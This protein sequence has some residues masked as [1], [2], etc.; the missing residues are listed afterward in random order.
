MRLQ[1][2]T[3]DPQITKQLSALGKK[4]DEAYNNNDAAAVAALYTEDAVVV[5]DTGPIYGREAI[6]KHWADVFKQV[7]FSK[8]LDKADQDSPHIIGTAGNEAWSNGEWSTTIQGQNFG[9]V[10]SKGY[11]S[12]ITVRE[13]D[14]WRKRMQMSNVARNNQV[15]LAISFAVPAF[16]QQKDTVD[17][18]IIEQL[19]ALGKKFDEAW[20]NNDATALAVL[21]T[22]D[23]V[24]VTD[25][26]PLYG[27]EAIEKGYADLFKQVHFSN[28][29]S[30]RD[31]Y[32]PHIIG[33]AGNEVWS[34]GE[35]SQTYQV[36]G[37]DPIQL[38]GYWS[39]IQVREGDAWKTRMTMSNVTP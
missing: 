3:A 27:R 5:A 6:E 19:D 33:T 15:G 35:W 29:I 26:G 9:P 38:K 34:N 23:A 17:P 21:Y 11:F 7:H 28:R 20:K 30:K 37:G 10:H 18:Q 2:D 16:A 39:N 1:K 14:V 13:G 32:S 12:S 4:T 31:Q 24:R 8:H 25:T 36:N 22:E